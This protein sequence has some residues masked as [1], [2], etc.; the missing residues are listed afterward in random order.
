MTC[1]T[2]PGLPGNWINGWLAAVGTTVLDSRMRLHW[3][4]G[5]TPVAVLSAD[6]VDPIEVLAESWPSRASLE[7]LPIAEHWESTAPLLRK[8]PVDAFV[9]RARAARSHPHSWTLSSTLTDL[10]VDKNGEVPHAPFDP[11]GPG[12]T[13]WLHHRLLK[14]HRHVEPSVAQLADS[15][16]GRGTRVRDNGLG[17]DFT[18]LGSLADSSDKW[19]NPVAEVLAFF[20]LAILPLRG[21]GTDERFGSSSRNRATQ[22]GWLAVGRNRRFFWPAWSHSLD[23]RAIDALMDAW[24]PDR[25]KTW[26]LAGIHAG[27][28]IVPYEAR[29]SGDPTRGF[30][31]ERL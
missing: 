15:L 30:G 29:G 6:G 27:W 10:H 31:S 24:L 3:T 14:V 12:T 28:R 16:T 5:G 9:Q 11:A 1:T 8:V 2:C 13:K 18:R 20:G 23:L 25:K 4:V 22:R 21:S 7:D 26:P 17:F 19:V